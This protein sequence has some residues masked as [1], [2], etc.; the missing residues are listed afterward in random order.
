M[1]D[2][3]GSGA[4]TCPESIAFAGAA[5]ARADSVKAGIVELRQSDAALRATYEVK[6][7]DSLARIAKLHKVW[8]TLIE[9]G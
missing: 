9:L 5:Q 6:Q 3:T 1:A 7:G 2:S 4:G 8:N